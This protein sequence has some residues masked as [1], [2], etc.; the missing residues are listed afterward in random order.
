MA[1]GV[2]PKR[3]MAELCGKQLELPVWWNLCIFSKEQR[4][5][6]GHGIVGAKIPLGAGINADKHFDRKL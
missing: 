2:D 3:I 6:S 5:Y 4:F 1:M